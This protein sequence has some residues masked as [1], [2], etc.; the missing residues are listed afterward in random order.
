[1]KALHL[2]AAIAALALSMPAVAQDKPAAWDVNAPPMKTRN[3]P[4]R[5]D[6]GT[7]MN[8][9]VSPDGSR[10][11][12]DLLGDIY[13]M[14]VAG[15][16][17]TRIAEGL[18]YEQHPRFSPDGSRIAFTSDRGGGDNIWIMNAN[19][20]DK[21]QL[22]K[23]TFRLLNNPSWSPDG[24]YIVARKHFTTGR[25]LGTGELWLYHVSG[26]NGVQLVKRPSEVHQKELGEPMFAPD[27]KGIFY[28]KD[29]TPGPI[30]EYAQDSNAQLFVIDRYDMDTGK[31]ERVT[32]GPGGAARPQPSPDGR[33]LA[34][35]RRERAKT[36]LYVR[37]MQTGEE[38]KIY[39]AMDRD[40]QETWAVHGVYPNMGW[41]PDSARVIFWAGG[42]IRSID[43]A[44][45]AETV[46]PFSVNDSRTVVDPIRPQKPVA[47]DTVA[48][49][50][51]RFASVSPDGG[52]MVF[53]ALGK[54]HHQPATGGAVQPLV[55][56]GGTDFELFPAFSRDGS[57]IVYVSWDD[58]RLGELRVVGAAGGEART[59]SKSPGHFRRPQ[60]SPDGRSVV[61]EAG[62]GGGLTSDNWGASPGV[63]LLDIAS[64]ETRRITSDGTE[65][66]FGATSDRVYFSRGADGKLAL[67]STDL[68]GEAE[69]THASGEMVSGYAL[70]PD[71]KTL[72]FRQNYAAYVMPFMAGAVDLGA[73][74]GGG[75]LPA[76]Q[77]SEGG[78]TFLQWSHNG[79]QLNWSLGPVVYSADAARAITSGPV[80]KADAKFAAPKTGVVINVSAPADKPSGTVAFTNARIVTMADD[81][82]GIVERGTVVVR[83][84]RI[85]AVGANVAVP[86]GAQTVDVAGKTII[87][88][89]IDA[90]AHGPQGQ[91]DIIPQQNWNAVAHL[92]L[93]V[94]TIHDPSNS[95]S[96]IFPAASYQRVGKYLAPRIFSTGEVVYG[97]KAAGIFAEIDS[98]ADARAHTSR[99]KLQGA[100]SVKNYNQPRRDQ[101]Q[102]VVAASQADNLASVAEGGSLFGMDISLI[103]DGNTTL[104]HNIPVET[105]YEDV[106]SFFAQSKV[107]Y[108]PTLVVT[109]GGPA[110]DP[111]WRS[112]MDVWSHPIL[113]KHVP[114]RRL[115]ATS[116]RREIA[117]EEDYS[118]TA[119]AREAMELAKRGVLVGIG[120]HGQE[121]GLASHWELWSFVKGG[122]TP[123]E[124]LRTATISGARSLGFD[125]DIGSIEPGKLADLVIID[126]DPV[127]DIRQ[128]DK[129][130][131]VMLNGRLYE[132]PTM[133]E[134]LTGTSTL[135]T[136]YWEK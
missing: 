118:D 64:G 41:T 54:L 69:R 98:L 17:A 126:G 40:V 72:A 50:M 48:V 46:I 115:E 107:G 3:I 116:V 132:V 43:V 61:Y 134:T 88:G 9:D 24:Q 81:A 106:R 5:V 91:D 16:A 42:K 58:A 56:N 21:R 109:Y 7:W 12:F 96:E 131:H 26:G 6:E 108:T 86:A 90:H 112:H 124:A 97:A 2:S 75:A 11:V 125:K 39:D 114:R 121:E 51:P 92:A 19:G 10:I 57:Q 89:L 102:Q 100:H 59:I 113:S 111:Y 103:A 133:N 31:V 117:P 127:A 55:S 25:S 66:H 38:R 83:D 62:S 32:G 18:A 120:A 35:V 45:G 105:L 80:G 68:S 136:W 122:M 36:K 4:I 52:R 130:T 84:N 94:T 74:R 99:L 49:T 29:S 23:E 1:M 70:A 67:V 20:S 13:I 101:R 78:A 135:K 34:F 28:S 85:V 44:S 110:A 129:I 76:V 30:F 73:G 47:P 63:Y 123:L 104:E 87:P 93:G 77:V 33:Y 8:L 37:D 53:E 82:G 60:F 27:G 22:T 95:A 119:S 79:R 71:G 65:P 14:P 15:G 128:S